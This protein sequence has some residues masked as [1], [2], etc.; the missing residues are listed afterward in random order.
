MPEESNVSDRMSQLEDLHR[1]LELDV[2]NLNNEIERIKLMSPSPLPIEA[3]Q[4]IVEL[5]RISKDI[6]T[7]KLWKKTIEEV[8]FL[9]SVVMVPRPG[10]EGGGMFD[11]GLMK[12]IKDDM[13]SMQRE[14]IQLKMQNAPLPPGAAGKG[15]GSKADMKAYAK[16]A[17]NAQSIRMDMEKLRNMLTMKVAEMET[18]MK[19]AREMD[20]RAMS[21]R[22]IKDIEMM[23]RLIS[24]GKPGVPLPP[25]PA[26]HVDQKVY[27]R[28]DA[29]ERG[30]QYMKD[31]VDKRMAALSA[32][33][34]AK[35]GV[36]LP[37]GRGAE[38]DI[39]AL[40][41]KIDQILGRLEKDESMIKS[42]YDETN[43]PGRKP[44]VPLP[45][46]AAPP[47]EFFED[48]QSIKRSVAETRGQL[49]SIIGEVAKLKQA[50]YSAERAGAA[51]RNRPDLAIL[52]DRLD[53][54][55]KRLYSYRGEMRPIIVE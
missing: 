6:E 48:V 29:L 26:P 45:P 55:E 2:I 42:I 32:G 23:K 21:D 52:K 4:R 8:K 1:V 39:A 18:K 36:P 43:K 10:G 20:M 17:E 49:G 53:R 37:P 34:P 14:I 24:G 35:P 11:A 47:K 44:G 30:F 31:L 5:E 46:G 41:G 50:V 19:A 33:A 22:Y 7:F 54:I 25:A 3:E 40:K 16:S 28:I 27:S 51:D 15:K 12:A 13:D 38:S 9:R